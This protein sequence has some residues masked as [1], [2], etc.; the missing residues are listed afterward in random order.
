MRRKKKLLILGYG[1]HARSVADVAISCG[2]AELLFV[3]SNANPS[4]NF[5]GYRVIE[6]L[7]KL[8]GTWTDAFPASG[9]SH[10]RK[11]QCANIKETG[12]K[13]ISLISPLSSIGSGAI[14]QSGNFIGHHAHVGPMA[15]I[16]RACII[17]SAAII[18]HESYIGEYSHL[19]VNATICGRTK[20]GTFCTVGAGATVIDGLT[21]VDDTR[22]GAGAVVINSITAPGTYVGVPVQRKS[23]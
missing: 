17:N 5:L 23:A 2:Y 18:E 4:E 19:S 22:I 3:D 16:G 11:D 9:N 7:D 14:I 15:V 1:G 13:L 6:S 12:L 21:V 8:K 20:I 10:K